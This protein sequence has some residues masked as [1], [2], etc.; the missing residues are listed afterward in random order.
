[1]NEVGAA[2]EI[3]VTL[4]AD[5]RQRATVSLGST[6]VPPG[7]PLTGTGV[8]GALVTALVGLLR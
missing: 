1:M 7:F 2:S 6:L 8:Q 5:T 3:G 4:D